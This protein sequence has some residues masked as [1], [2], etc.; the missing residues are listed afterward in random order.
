M[1]IKPLFFLF[2]LSFSLFSCSIQDEI[3]A[4]DVVDEISATDPLNQ[5]D[6]PEIEEPK[7]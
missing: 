7:G 6:D 1:L 4:D 3:I 5:D 2:V